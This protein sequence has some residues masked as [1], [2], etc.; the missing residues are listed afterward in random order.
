MLNVGGNA[1]GLSRLP[2]A[3]S[4][5]SVW[6]VLQQ[7]TWVPQEEQKYR[8]PSVDDA[9]AVGVPATYSNWATGT[10]SQVTWGAA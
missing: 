8:V 6:P 10:T 3:T 2:M 7:A 4:M 5:I 9:S 1:S